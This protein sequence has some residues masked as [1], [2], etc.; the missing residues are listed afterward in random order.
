M[1]LGESNY[2]ACTLHIIR[3]YYAYVYS[4]PGAANTLAFVG[5][6]TRQ[7]QTVFS[8]FLPRNAYA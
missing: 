6:S 2:T 8:C 5:D 3:R 7:L 1:W 4:G